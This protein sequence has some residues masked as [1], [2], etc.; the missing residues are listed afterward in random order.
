MSDVCRAGQ[1]APQLI[2]LVPSQAIAQAQLQAAGGAVTI[3]M[4]LVGQVWR[5]LGSLFFTG[6]VTGTIHWHRTAAMYN[7]DIICSQGG[8][9]MLGRNSY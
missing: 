5:E 8:R 3:P 2:Q 7:D 6:D 9:I 4:S 1:G